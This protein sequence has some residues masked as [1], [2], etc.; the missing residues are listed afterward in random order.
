MD[1]VARP[2]DLAALPRVSRRAASAGRALA[3]TLAYLPARLEVELE[4]LGAVS[5][6]VVG[7]SEI[8][9]A[10]PEQ[11]VFGLSHAG[12]AGRLL[13]D[14]RFA[15]R[16]VAAVLGA[17]TPAAVHR[18]GPGE[19][20]LLAGQ[21][22]VLL[23]RIGAPATV[24][25]SLAAAAPA[26]MS[27]GSA[28]LAKVTAAGCTG[29]VRFEIPPAWLEAAGGGAHWKA[30]AARLP[31]EARVELASTRIAAA[32][33]AAASAGDG[34]VFDAVAAVDPGLAAWPIRL[35]IGA[36]AASASIAADGAITVVEGLRPAAAATDNHKE[37][38]MG[39]SEDASAALAA[40]P[41]EVVAE[42][43]RLTL[44]GDEVLGLAPGV[45]LALGT[46]ERT[47][48]VVLRVGGELWA[49]GELVDVDGEL[50]VRITALARG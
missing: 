26:H 11:V 5:V 30:R 35:T 46:A 37:R 19:R 28:L 39:S 33:W 15:Q 24:G 23:D 20:G 50:G 2:L 29:W 31:V 21:L 27:G 17:V 48:A 14:A 4:P 49:H 7:A 43:G 9:P 40:A 6:V 45:V 42:I 41:V 18:L 36:F 44:R 8:E 10:P 3:R 12:S 13:V 1:E 34:V 16:L 32:A 25:V 38:D 47:R 22:A